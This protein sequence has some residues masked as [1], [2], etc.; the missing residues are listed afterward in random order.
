MSRDKFFQEWMTF[1]HEPNSMLNE[2]SLN[3]LNIL[4]DTEEFSEF[5]NKE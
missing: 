5:K 3:K 2:I 4:E 1:F